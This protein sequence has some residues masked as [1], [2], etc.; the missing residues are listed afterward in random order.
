MR[1][2]GLDVG[3]KT[4]GVAI[5]DPLGFTAQGVEIIKINEEAKEFGFDRLG[6]LV[7]EYQV[8]KFV[9]GL[10]KNMNNTEGPRV[11][12]SKA[13][14]DK[15]KEIFNLPV[16]YQDERLTTV[17]AERML[18]EQADVSR[19]KRKKVIDKLAA[20]LILQNYLDRMF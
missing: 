17:Q 13:Y 5:S 19:G 12:A 4:V 9:V 7:K 15:I 18:V 6:E 20:Q 16:D 1:V 10:P 8:D 2:M 11:E 14:G 3:S